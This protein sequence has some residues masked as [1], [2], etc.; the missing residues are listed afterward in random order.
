MA[1]L[2]APLLSFSASG[3]IAKSLV[4]FPW[5]GIDV[6]RQYVV[7]ANPRSTDQTAQRNLMTAAVLAWHDALYT[8]D[9]VTAWNRFAGVL[10]KIMSGYN[11]MVRAHI[12]E[13]ILGNTWEEIRNLNTD[14]VTATNIKVHAYKASAGNAPTVYWGTRKTH[15]PDSA[16]LADL[17][18]DHWMYDIP[19]LNASTLYYYY[20]DVGSSGTD[21]G[22][23]GIGQQRT[24]A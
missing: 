18:A 11:A 4:Y 22:R 7:P 3:Q 20:V 8:A 17:G 15:F 5:K 12:D 14:S 21:Y 9:D 1:K 2:N 19:G 10:A 16:P 6:V 13:G 23:T 24:T